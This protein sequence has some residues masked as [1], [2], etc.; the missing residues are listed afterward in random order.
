MTDGGSTWSPQSIPDFLRSTPSTPK[1]PSLPT[2]PV[3]LNPSTHSCVLARQTS[4]SRVGPPSAPPPRNLPAPPSKGLPYWSGLADEILIFPP[5]SSPSGVS[6]SPAFSSNRDLPLPQ[7]ATRN[8][9]REL[10]RESINSKP[11]AGRTVKKAISHQSISKR[12]SNFPSTPRPSTPADD[13]GDRAP[14]KQRSFHHNSR[15]ILPPVPTSLRNPPH[16]PPQPQPQPALPSSSSE[17][18]PVVEQRRGSATSFSGRKRLFSGGSVKRPSSQI[19]SPGVA[20]DDLEPVFISEPDT[21]EG[22]MAFIDPFGRSDSPAGSVGNEDPP[23]SPLTSV[24][25]TPQRIMSPAEMLRIEASW[26][27]GS[28]DCDFGVPRLRVHSFASISTSMSHG[29]GGLASPIPKHYVVDRGSILTGG[30]SHGQRETGISSPLRRTLQT[31]T[32]HASMSQ[33]GS[34]SPTHSS[35]HPPA[36]LPPPPRP[37]RQ[38]GNS[39]HQALIVPLSPRPIRRQNSKASTRSQPARSVMRKSSFLEI[40]DETQLRRSIPVPS[41]FAGSFL[42]LERGKD[43]FDTI[44]SDDEQES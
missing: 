21:Q 9:E 15:S 11:L 7:P 3:W 10:D 13:V 32:S 30:G 29:A 4:G 8:T 35:F 31:S 22:G 44:R 37:R 43:S 2:S 14:R 6:F 25:Y 27:D 36:G 38:T 19:L 33:N 5:M 24:E 16:T 20:D 40:E 34:N 1:V 18:Q 23:G 28:E 39:E 42:D 17:T 41:K 26:N 12:S